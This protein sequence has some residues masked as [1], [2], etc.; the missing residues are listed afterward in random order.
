MKGPELTR[1]HE[2]EQVLVVCG[3]VKLS[4]NALNL[5]VGKQRS[6]QLV[7]NRLDFFD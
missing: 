1:Q 5:T 3:I 4:Q 6:V 2:L 7:D